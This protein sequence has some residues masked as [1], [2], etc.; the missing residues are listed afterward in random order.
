MNLFH[1]NGTTRAGQQYNCLYRAYIVLASILDYEPKIVNEQPSWLSL[2]E[3]EG[4]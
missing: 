4:E 2:I 3:I 1:K